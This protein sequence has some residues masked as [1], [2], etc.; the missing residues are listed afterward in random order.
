MTTKKKIE[1]IEALVNSDQ[2]TLL[3]DR[4]QEHQLTDEEYLDYL[5]CYFRKASK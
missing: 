2:L 4:A 1:L 3:Q 5:T